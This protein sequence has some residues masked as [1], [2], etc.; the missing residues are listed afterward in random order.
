MNGIA[1]VIDAQSSNNALILF[2]K[3]GCEILEPREACLLEDEC[4]IVSE[5][6]LNTVAVSGYISGHAL[7][8]S[9]IVL[10]ASAHTHGCLEYI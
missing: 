2:L 5:R 3:G 6:I 8:G 4:A 1:D 9:G 10:G 7:N